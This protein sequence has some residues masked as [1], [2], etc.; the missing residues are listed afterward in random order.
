MVCNLSLQRFVIK[1]FQA[2]IIGTV[3]LFC[4]NILAYSEEVEPSIL[5]SDTA[6]IAKTQESG[7]QLDVI[8]D[9]SLRGFAHSDT[10]AD[11]YAKLT[12]KN[13]EIAL[14]KAQIR[15]NLNEKESSVTALNASRDFF[16]SG[17]LRD[18]IWYKNLL[19][20]DINLWTLVSSVFFVWLI[21]LYNLRSY[22]DI[23]VD[24][25]SGDPRMGEVGISEVDTSLGFESK[26]DLARA[27]M[28]AGNIDGARE[29][30]KDVMVSDS[31]DHRK[32]ATSMLDSLAN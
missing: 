22:H 21:L 19:N 8:A 29:I 2:I 17:S 11:L 15:Y 31:A 13:R 20:F 12:T 6:V 24:Q 23:K 7:F 28:D 5:S 16:S 9:Q 10:Y 27:F 30:L 1:N 26:L 25:K 4:V 3:G 32:E 14:L 18:P